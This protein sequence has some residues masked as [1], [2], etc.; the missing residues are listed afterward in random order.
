MRI[1]IRTVL[2]HQFYLCKVQS[3]IFYK[4]FFISPILYE[5]STLMNFGFLIKED[6]W[7]VVQILDL[8]GL[9]VCITFIR[10]YTKF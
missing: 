8:T 10:I 3:Y 2:P 1:E 5:G 9:N 4:H 7:Y 6:F